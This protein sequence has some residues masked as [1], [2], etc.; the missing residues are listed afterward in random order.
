M[1]TGT[2]RVCAD[3]ATSATEQVPSEHGPTCS[4]GLPTGQSC[5]NP[6]CRWPVQSRAFSRVDAVAM[7]SGPLA[8]CLKIYKYNRGGESWA[9]IF[10]RLDRVVP[11]VDLIV[12]NP[13]AVTRQPHQHV[14]R[15]LQAV[16][17]EDV[18][19]WW[20]FV[21]Q[22]Q[23][24]LVK[25]EETAKSA[26]SGWRAKMAAAEAHVDAIQVMDPDRHG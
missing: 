2:P 9:L 18:D 6:I 10:G 16:Q 15:M 19:R 24:V 1:R 26:G 25:P 22:D 13:T 7:Y 17:V 14:E 23:P 11:V 21:P 8:S 4:Q 3:C 20:P 12:G 5:C